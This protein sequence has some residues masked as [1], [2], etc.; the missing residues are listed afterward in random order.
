MKKIVLIDN[1]NREC[2]SYS[3][4]VKGYYRFSINEW[5][6]KKEF[7]EHLI[8]ISK[9]SKIGKIRLVLQQGIG[10]A[11]ITSDYDAEKLKETLAL[12]YRHEVVPPTR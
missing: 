10:K 5:D 2:F 1:F 9:E 12:N 7:L 3:D 11:V 8:T 4:S 6:M